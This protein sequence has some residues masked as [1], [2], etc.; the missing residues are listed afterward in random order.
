M[1]GRV[2]AALMRAGRPD[3]AN[4]VARGDYHDGTSIGVFLRVPKDIGKGRLPLG[5]QDTSPPHI[6]V[7]YVGKFP[8]E[9]AKYLQGVVQ[10][11]VR[12]TKPFR[13]QLDDKVTYF[14]PNDEGLRV[15]KLA[16]FSDDLKVLRQRLWDAFKSKGIPFSDSFP[17]YKPHLTLAYLK[18]GMT[19]QG[20]VPQGRWNVDNVE[21]WGWDTDTVVP[22]SPSR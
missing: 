9:K 8:Q 6:T 11:V 14:P 2:I 7:I 5:L 10:G 13:V 4:Y 12:G 20:P 17:K 21:L 18:P 22:F 1:C 3:L 19:Y 16:V 15:A